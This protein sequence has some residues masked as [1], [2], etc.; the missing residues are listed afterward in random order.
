MF[1]SYRNQSVDL[2]SNSNNGFYMTG[3]L[4]VKRLENVMLI[5]PKNPGLE[6]VEMI[7]CKHLSEDNDYP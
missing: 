3:T 2:Q 1:P 4:V 7:A 5:M 6:K